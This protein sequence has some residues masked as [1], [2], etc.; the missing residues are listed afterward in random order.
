MVQGNQPFLHVRARTHLLRAAEEDADLARAH[1][2]EQSQ[3][4]GVG[5]V[6]LDE[7]DLALGDAHDLQLVAMSR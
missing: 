5:I 2:S 3:L 7:G 1:V 4:R 6:V